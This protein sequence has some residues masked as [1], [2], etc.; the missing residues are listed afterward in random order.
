MQIGTVNKFD[1]MVNKALMKKMAVKN[2][3]RD[4]LDEMHENNETN[5]V[6]YRYNRFRFYI[7]NKKLVRMNYDGTKHVCD[8]TYHYGRN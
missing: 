1:V 3:L 2:D 7:F 8:Y 6:R 4:Q 5:T